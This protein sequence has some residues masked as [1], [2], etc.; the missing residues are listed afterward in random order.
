MVPGGQ[1]APP[2]L[3][4][5]P[6]SPHRTFFREGW[7][8][9]GPRGRDV[10]TEALFGAVIHIFRLHSTLPGTEHSWGSVGVASSCAP[11][12][13]QRDPGGELLASAL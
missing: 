7:V 11:C 9:G 2:A 4:A 12:K 6:V 3:P 13:A 8:A 1:A 5:A 10:G